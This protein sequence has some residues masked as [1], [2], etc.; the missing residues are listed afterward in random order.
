MAVLAR[1]TLAASVLIILEVAAHTSLGRIFVFVRGG[2]AFDAFNL[3]MLARQHKTGHSMVEV[4][5]FPIVLGVAGITG[6]AKFFP[7]MIIFEVAVHAFG[8]QPFEIGHKLRPGM[9]FGAG[10]FQMRAKRVKCRLGVVKLFI[11]TFFAIMAGAAVGGI[12]LGMGSH[13]R[14]VQFGMAISTV[15]GLEGFV[16]ADMTGLANKSRTIRNFLVGGGG[17]TEQFVG[18]FVQGNIGQRGA[19]ATVFGMAFATFE[20]RLLVE[21]NSVEFMRICQFQLDIGM[22]A[23]AAILHEIPIPGRGM[24]LITGAADLSMRADIPQQRAS[25][26][27]Q[28]TR[29]KK[30]MALGKHSSCN[31]KECDCGGD[32]RRPC[33]AAQLIFIFHTRPCVELLFASQITY[34]KNVA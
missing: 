5:I 25:F 15:T 19:C 16:T 21:Q 10:Q 28:I 33:H 22:A 24:A 23:H 9:T 13:E 7:M 3:F 14:F 26:R 18:E 4:G 27:I 6:C 32:D 8:G 12:L 31:D 1:R 29:A 2:V 34:F 11:D 20:H 30:P 17:K